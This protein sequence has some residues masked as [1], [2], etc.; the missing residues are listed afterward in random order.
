M[1]HRYLKKNSELSTAAIDDKRDRG[2]RASLAS[3]RDHALGNCLVIGTL[4]YAWE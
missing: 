1:K 3:L 4:S 2:G